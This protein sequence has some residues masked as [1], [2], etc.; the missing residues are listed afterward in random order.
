MRKLSFTAAIVALVV[1]AY[2]ALGSRLLNPVEIPTVAARQGTLELTLRATGTVDAKRAVS[3]TAPRVRNIQITWMAP[4]GTMVTSGD[5]VIRFDSSVQEAD[6]AEHRSTLQINLASLE[7]QQ[8]ELAIQEKE[9]TLAL[10][11]AQRKFDEQK[12]EAPK[13]AEEA[14]L[15]LELAELNARAKLD[16]IRADVQKA[17]L[18]VARAK[19]KLALA[20]KEF[21]QMTL[22]APIPGMV[23]YL[24]I[25]KGNGMSKVQQGDS[26]WPGQ[27]L[28]NLPDLS[29]MIVNATV[30]EV[31][32]NQVAVDQDVTI[33]LD[34]FPGVS[35]KGRVASKGT[36]ARKKEP[37]SKINV[38]D[39]Q[40]AIL[41]TDERLKP[42]M[43]AS[44]RVIV[45]RVEDVVVLPIE[46]VFEAEGK[47]TVYLANGK[48]REVS[49]GRRSDTEIEITSGVSAGE[50]VCVVDPTIAA[51]EAPEEKATEP[52]INR[53]RTP[54]GGSPGGGQRGRSGS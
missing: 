9:L 51:E 17:E 4:E 21:E 38:F 53:G 47:P 30:S 20:Q 11:Q 49:V 5:P 12:H 43:S 36:L 35:F 16:Q 24:G 42:G 2:L 1:F 48:P 22:N 8:Q 3:I 13:I 41:E 18:E 7:R 39:V 29:E 44:C 45:E 27:G 34:A 15:E 50:S 52:E 23:V 14:R 46:A 33:A 37:N 26:P 54:A 6:L 19:D 10:R 28:I 31:D 40:I 32:A 25:W